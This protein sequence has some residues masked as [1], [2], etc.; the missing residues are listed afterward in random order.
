MPFITNVINQQKHLLFKCQDKE[1]EAQ[2]WMVVFE[3]LEM[4]IFTE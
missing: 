2:Y 4:V 1:I 3:L